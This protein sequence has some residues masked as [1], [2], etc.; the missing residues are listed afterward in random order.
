MKNNCTQ[1]CA[2]MKTEDGD[3]SCEGFVGNHKMTLDYAENQICVRFVRRERDAAKSTSALLLQIKRLKNDWFRTL[4]TGN[5]ED[6]YK[7]MR[8][9]Y[10]NHVKD[11]NY[12]LRLASMVV[13]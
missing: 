3:V 4:E 5:V 12:R 13:K 1:C 11:C 6:C 9:R 10:E 2:C 8:K 7:E